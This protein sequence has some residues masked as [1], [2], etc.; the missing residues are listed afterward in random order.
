[1]SNTPFDRIWDQHVVREYGGGRA[2]IHIDRHF[3]QEGTSGRAFDGL[4]ERGLRCGGRT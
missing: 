1:M 2:L 3:A 4:R